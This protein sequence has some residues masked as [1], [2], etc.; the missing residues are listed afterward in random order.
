MN[1]KYI[2][3]PIECKACKESHNVDSDYQIGQEFKCP[4]CEEPCILQ[5]EDVEQIEFC[6]TENGIK[7][8]HHI[9]IDHEKRKLMLGR[10]ISVSNRET[11]GE[12]PT[13]YV[14]KKYE[15]TK[16]EFK[17]NPDWEGYSWEKYPNEDF[18]TSE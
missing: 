12:I 8:L 3:K 14:N 13:C 6:I 10:F 7:E 17:N 11:T 5:R 2:F 4:R 18:S 16:R 1:Y 15:E 9:K